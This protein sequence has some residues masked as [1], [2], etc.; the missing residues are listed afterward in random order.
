MLLWQHWLHQLPA[1]ALEGRQQK[2]LA[3]AISRKT[4]LE[5]TLLGCLDFTMPLKFIAVHV[6]EASGC[7][8]Y[9]MQPPGMGCARSIILLLTFMYLFTLT[10]ITCMYLLLTAYIL[11]YIYIYIYIYILID[12]T[13]KMVLKNHKQALQHILMWVVEGM[14][15]T[16]AQT[17]ANMSLQA[18]SKAGIS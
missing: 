2:L 13:G 14:C 9:D 3:P 7:C 16:Q 12:I 11:I 15:M 1:D 17:C 5:H 6:W 8:C 18:P 10:L 4:L